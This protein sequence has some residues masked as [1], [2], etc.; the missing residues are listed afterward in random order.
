M[1]D[2]V[3]RKCQNC[4]TLNLNKDYC[5]QCGALINKLLERKLEREKQEINK[6]RNTKELNRNNKFFVFLQKAK[7]HP[8]ILVRSIVKFLYSIWLLVIAIGSFLAF[9]MGYIAA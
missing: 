9:V 3:Y 1:S 8:N 5:E 6:I 7:T 4:G 2:K